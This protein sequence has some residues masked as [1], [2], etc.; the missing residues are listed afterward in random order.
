MVPFCKLIN[1]ILHYIRTLQQHLLTCHRTTIEEINAHNKV[2]D[3]W[4]NIRHKDLGIE[5]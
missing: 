1:R 5:H 4:R 2:M 3:K